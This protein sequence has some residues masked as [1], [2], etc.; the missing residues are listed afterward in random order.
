MKRM[1]LGFVI[2]IF[3]WGCQAGLSGVA[4]PVAVNA[5]PLKYYDGERWRELYVSSNEV[6]EFVAPNVTQESPIRSA[7]PGATLLES[8]GQVKFWRIGEG[9]DAQVLTRSLAT[10]KQ[11]ANVSP[12][13]HRSALG[14][15]R[16][17]LGGGVVVRLPTA[18]GAAEVDHWASRW[19]LTIERRLSPDRNLYVI[20]S[21][22]GM[23]ALELAN[24]MQESG[25]VESATP[26]WW[27][28]VEKR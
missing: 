7:S 22:P 23:A 28:E 13:F 18:W 2:A 24:K 8:K 16:M 25:E 14:G 5:T 27:V 3:G 15:G 10:Q 11:P 1:M 9:Q 26:Q 4:A 19:Q 6:A 20:A 21:L 12:V 17:A